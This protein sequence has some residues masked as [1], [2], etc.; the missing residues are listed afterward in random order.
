[1]LMVPHPTSSHSTLCNPVYIVFTERKL[2]LP[3]EGIADA[4][5]DTLL[6][7]LDA[8]SSDLGGP[9]GDQNHANHAS[10][11]VLCMI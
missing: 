7:G 5:P 3:G 6:D 9:E 10:R 1:L 8:R 11:D 4:A 2:R